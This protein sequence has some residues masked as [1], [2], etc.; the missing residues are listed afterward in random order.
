MVH[1]KFDPNS[2]SLNDYEP[3]QVGAGEYSV[4]YGANPYQRGF[5]YYQHGSGI[6]DFFRTLWR[7]MLPLV[8][9]TGKAMG[10]EA[11][12]TGSRILEKVAQGEN[13]KATVGD[14]ALKGVEN[15]IE[16]ARQKQNGGGYKKA[17]FRQN[18]F[19]SSNLSNHSNKLIGKSVLKSHTLLNK[20]K[21]PIINK[22]RRRSDA[23]GFY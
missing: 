1:V 10:Q 18:Q 23:F 19:I 3:N 12:S 7:A 6:S 15:L 22:K 16:K 13:L 20:L 17:K 8:K 21:S 4:F 2:V 11:L 5:G 9:S 14:E